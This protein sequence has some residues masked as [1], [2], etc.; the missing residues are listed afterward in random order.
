ML[1][2]L[3]ILT[4][5]WLAFWALLALRLLVL[6][7]FQSILVIIIVHFIFAGIPLLLDFVIG[8][9]YYDRYLGFRLAMQDE[10]TSV[11]YCFYVS[12]IP[13]FWW[14]L[15]RVKNLGSIDK[16]S[17]KLLFI[18][19]F[20]LILF[21]LLISP[22]FVLAFSPASQEY[23]T[24][25]VIATGNLVDEA[26]EYHRY[27]SLATLLSLI[28]GVGLLASQS[29]I[30]LL[31][32]ISIL[33]WLIIAIWL[34]GKRNIVALTIF[35]L[36][37]IFWYKG[38]L[39]G[40]KLIISIAVSILFF[41]GFSSVYQGAVRGISVELIS[42]QIVYERFRLDYGR[43][44]TIKLTIFAELHPNLI[45]VLNYRGESILFY[46][47]MYVPRDI[48]NEKPLPYSQYFTSAVFR[49]PPKLWGWS[50]TT[51]F[52]E[53]AIANF[54]WYGMIIGP[55]I[56]LIICRVGDS[57][58]NAVVSALTSLISS[59]LLAVQLVSFA[60]LFFLWGLI[61]VVNPRKK[62]HKLLT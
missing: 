23:L 39:R 44:H 8:Q 19:K 3:N 55:A 24:Y 20:K 35:L 34:N 33:P 14:F 52:L 37:Y 12:I 29:R 5:I 36:G 48:W 22:I 28:G 11:I 47:T 25:G 53:E 10:M 43:D 15:G 61:V 21:I 56:P 59:L 49:N 18:R 16:S 4:F 54:G 57:S 38:Y 51:S 40:T 31:S 45:N 6:G 2:I 26:K 13:P 17:D 27:I 7:R 60:P 30:K 50:F 46:L 41:A 42:P 1:D 9:P 58:K 62:N 32:L